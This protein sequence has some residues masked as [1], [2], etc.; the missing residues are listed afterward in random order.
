[1]GDV[2]TAHAGDGVDLLDDDGAADED[3]ELEAD[4]GDDRDEGVAKCVPDDDDAF[5]EALGPGGT[6]VVLAEGF[7]HG[8]PG[9]SHDGAGECAAQD[10]GWD[11]HEFEVADGVIG[12]LDVGSWR[13]AP[14]EVAAGHAD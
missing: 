8:G 10:H 9:E 13:D 11:G 3:G 12:E 5:A 2:V 7:E 4:D 14:L 1:G 6:D